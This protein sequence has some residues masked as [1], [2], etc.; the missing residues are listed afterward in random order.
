MS[1]IKPPAYIVKSEEESDAKGYNPRVVSRLCCPCPT[2]PGET[3]SGGAP[4]VQLLRGGG[5]GALFRQDRHR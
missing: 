4:H 2:L 1:T 5:R 3:P